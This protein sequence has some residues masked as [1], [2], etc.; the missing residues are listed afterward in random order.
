MKYKFSNG[1]ILSNLNGNSIDISIYNGNKNQVFTTTQKP[2]FWNNTP[3]TVELKKYL[4][5]KELNIYFKT[6]KNQYEIK[7]IP[8]GFSIDEGG[9][10]STSEDAKGEMDRKFISFTPT[11]ITKKYYNP[12]ADNTMLD[13]SFFTAQDVITT[14]TLP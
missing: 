11:W 10:Y 13:I 14:V 4:T 5:D 6:F 7:F 2:G 12:D 3:L 9:L 1:Y 8:G